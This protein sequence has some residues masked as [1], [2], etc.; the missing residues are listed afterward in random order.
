MHSCFACITTVCTGFEMLFHYVYLDRLMSDDIHTSYTCH[1]A[2]R[3]PLLSA[4]QES[5]HIGSFDLPRLF[6]SI[7][8]VNKC[9]TEL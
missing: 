5:V 1:K 9:H 4:L 2:T 8:I 3:V 7:I 6:M